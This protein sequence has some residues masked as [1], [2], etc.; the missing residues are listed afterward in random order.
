LPP[1]YSPAYLQRGK[2]P[3][4]ST[5]GGPVTVSRIAEVSRLVHPVGPGPLSQC[6][7]GGS[8]SHGPYPLSAW[9]A[10]T[11]PTTMMG[12]SPILRRSDLHCGLTLSV[13]TIPG[14]STYQGLV[15][16]SRDY[17][18]PEGRLATCY[19]AVCHAHYLVG[20]RLPWL[21]PTPIAVGSGRINRYRGRKAAG[22][23]RVV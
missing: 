8:R 5:R 15:P 9:R 3:L 7:S 4:R 12:R 2:A 13:E 14:I 16:V 11:P 19:S 10:I 22:Y 17:P 6:P 23:P 18:C 20:V 21:S 1:A